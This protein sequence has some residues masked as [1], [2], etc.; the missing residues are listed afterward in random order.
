MSERRIKLEIDPRSGRL[1]RKLSSSD[2][3]DRVLESGNR[4]I[5]IPESLFF[6]GGQRNRS[7]S[8]D[9]RIE[10]RLQMQRENLGTGCTSGNTAG[11]T[12]CGKYNWNERIYQQRLQQFIIAQ[13]FISLVD[14]LLNSPEEE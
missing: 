12:G 7:G 10:M 3:V 4:V 14:L 13:L 1:V 2:N 8:E 9:P 6:P 11:I 5:T